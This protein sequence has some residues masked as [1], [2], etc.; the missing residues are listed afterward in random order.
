MLFV[1]FFF[2]SSLVENSVMDVAKTIWSCLLE[3][4][5]DSL[6][7]RWARESETFYENGQ[8]PE[9]CQGKSLHMNIRCEKGREVRFWRSSS[10]IGSRFVFASY[11]LEM[12]ASPVLKGQE[13]SDLAEKWFVWMCTFCSVLPG[14]QWKSLHA[15]PIGP[16]PYIAPCLL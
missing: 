12:T 14:N 13:S 6:I 16:P 15:L 4:W 3:Q 10:T 7:S 8:A 11:S 1:A 5:D 9:E 2:P